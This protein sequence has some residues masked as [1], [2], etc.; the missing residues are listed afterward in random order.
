MLSHHLCWH[1]ENPKGAYNAV[2]SREYPDN[3][4][5]RERA[6]FTEIN[7]LAFTI[8]RDLL[9]SFKFYM[10]SKRDTFGSYSAIVQR[11][12]LTYWNEG[13]HFG[14]FPCSNLQINNL[15]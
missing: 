9:I 3:E 1:A 6:Q 10:Q 14:T 12:Y 15:K 2:E 11:L 8:F 13:M 7:L 5:E 4:Q